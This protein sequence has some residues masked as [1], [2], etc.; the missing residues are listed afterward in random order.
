[1]FLSEKT[2]RQWNVSRCEARFVM[3]EQ[4]GAK[5]SFGMPVQCMRE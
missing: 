2:G 1:M 3:P 4:G 5:R